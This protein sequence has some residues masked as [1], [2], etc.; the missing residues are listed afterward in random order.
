LNISVTIDNDANAGA[1]GSKWHNFKYQEHSHIL[2]LSIN[3]NFSG[4]GAGFIIDHKLYRGAHGAAG[5]IA[6]FITKESWKQF[7]SSAK[8]KY[9][10]NS[11]ICEYTESEMPL[12]SDV[13]ALAKKEDEG[14]KYIL[15]E[16]ADQ[17][18]QKLVPLVDLF[19]PQLIVIG[20]DI[21][22]AETYIKDSLIE[23]LNKNVMSDCAR[24]TPLFFS[25]FGTYSVA[26]GSTALILNEIFN[27]D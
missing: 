2:Y 25:P 10:D 20:G 4:M 17:I 18:S 16:I 3:Q 8:S 21:C 7:R 14:I 12:V 11:Y 22:D 15:S 1:L 6:S 23:K 26:M 24:K 5:E 27:S 13:I 9:P 19:D